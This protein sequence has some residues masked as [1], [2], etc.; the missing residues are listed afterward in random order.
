MF[1][2][3]WFKKHQKKL[4]WLLNNSITKRWFRYCLRIRKYDCSQKITEITP[5]SISWGDRYFE[6]KGKWYLERTTD[7]RTHNK[8]SKRLFHV[9]YPI[10]YSFH[11]WDIIVNFLKLPKLNLGFDT[12][13]VYPDPGDPGTTTV[14]GAVRSDRTITVNWATLRGSANAVLT[15]DLDNIFIRIYNSTG[16]SNGWRD[17]WRAFFGFDTSSLP[18]TATVTAATISISGDGIAENNGFTSSI[19]CV[20]STQASNTTLTTSDWASY[21]A[22][23]F[24]TRVGFASW[25][26]NAYNDFSLNASGIGNISKTGVSKFTF[27]E[28]HD[29]DNSEPAL[30]IADSIISCY[31]ADQT[32]TTQDPKLVVTYSMTVKKNNPSLLLMNVG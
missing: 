26:E 6:N 29:F 17:G 30:A 32:G 8:Y 31:F 23:E 13:T 22:T 1:D 18:D 5:N 25:N 15:T 10:W 28:S 9:F 4:L 27:L 16:A 3:F 12:L 24:I 7:F 2:K 11:I 21:G 14:D 20:A 19:V